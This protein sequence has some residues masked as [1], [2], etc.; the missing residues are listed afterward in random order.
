MEA[1]L[2]PSPASL[3]GR[4]RRRKPTLEDR[5]IARMLARWLDREIADEWGA[6]LS[7]AHAARAQ[8]LTREH[9][10]RSVARALDRLIER[11]ANP[12]PASLIAGVPPCREQVRE[13]TP[14]IVAIAA[15]LRAGEP[16]DPR[17]VARLKTLLS[18]RRGP[19]YEPTGPDALAVALDRVWELLD[20]GH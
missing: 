4:R 7:Q 9:T 8:Q 20:V 16:L 1:D 11:A 13:A 5:L 3:P 18:D 15:R 6:S 12:R 19:C 2:D 17:G 14:L 10:R